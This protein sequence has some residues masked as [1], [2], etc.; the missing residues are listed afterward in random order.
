MAQVPKR[1]QERF[2]K[3]I[4]RYQ[5]ILQSA[6]DRDVNESDTGAIVADILASV[7]GFDKYSEITSEFAIRGTFCDLAVKTNGNVQYL[8]EVKAIGLDLK[9][10]H[11]RQA[12]NYGANHGIPYVVLTNG[13]IWEIYRIRFEQ[14]VQ[15]DQI[16][17]INFLELNPR[18]KED[19]EKL[20]LLCKEGL[21]KKAIEE[22]QE[23]IQS[24][25]R[26]VV[27]AILLS[28]NV[29]DIVRREIRRMSPGL[30]VDSEEIAGILQNEVLKR[31]VIEGERATQAQR[32]VKKA[33]RRSLRKGKEESS[34][35]RIA[36]TRLSEPERAEPETKTH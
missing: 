7:F 5:R 25:N 35:E 34:A 16:C 28:D 26:F 1:V 20:F 31:E 32:R 27:G 3:E 2:S 10:N 30:R 4:G 15:H 33:G 19:H 18:R 23:H 11:L 14:P 12:V 6:K 36:D 21:T 24:V 13:V 29:V 9:E 17:M 8:I 22:F